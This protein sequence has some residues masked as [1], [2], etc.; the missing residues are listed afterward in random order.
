MLQSFCC[1]CSPAFL[2]GASVHFARPARTRSQL[3]AKRPPRAY[4]RVRYFRCKPGYGIYLPVTDVE[5]IEE[6]D[7]DEPPP[8]GEEENEFEQP[9]AQ[10][11]AST[12]PQDSRRWA[13]ADRQARVVLDICFLESTHTFTFIYATTGSRPLCVPSAR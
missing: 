5:K 2:R 1:S 10:A 11:F 3:N 12:R 9:C 4:L 13:P 7:D 8:E 6:D